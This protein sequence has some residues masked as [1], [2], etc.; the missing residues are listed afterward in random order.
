MSATS[1][2]HFPH[3]PLH[4]RAPVPRAWRR[5]RVIGTATVIAPIGRPAR[6]WTATPKAATPSSVCST[7]SAKPALR[8]PLPVR[9]ETRRTCPVSA[10]DP[11]LARRRRIGRRRYSCSSI[12]SGSSASRM[13]P[14]DGRFG[15][16]HL[17]LA[18]AHPQHRRRFRRRQEAHL[19]AHPDHQVDGFPAQCASASMCGRQR[20]VNSRVHPRCAGPAPIA[21]PG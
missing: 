18:I 3:R 5:N 16:Q 11:R 20:S 19:G 4:L 6:L 21:G 10:A 1:T 14:P 15:G 9:G 17:A 12:S 7:L 2:S 8:A 13:R